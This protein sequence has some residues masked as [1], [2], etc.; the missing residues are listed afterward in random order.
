MNVINEDENDHL[1]TAERRYKPVH[2][3]GV[4]PRTEPF[5]FGGGHKFTCGHI[6]YCGDH[7]QMVDEGQDCHLCRAV[8]AVL[9]KHN[10]PHLAKKDLV[11]DLVD[12]N[13]KQGDIW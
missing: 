5:A 3:R 12:T 10:V 4:E 6:K 2:A 9:E 11:K 13:L 8:I 7:V 1:S